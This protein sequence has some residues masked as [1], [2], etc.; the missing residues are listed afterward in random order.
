[1]T[2]TLL[3]LRA[4]HR[5]GVEFIVVGMTAAVLQGTPAVTL[6]LDLVY[7]LDPGNV[8]RLL[9][10]LEELGARF[11]HDDRRIPPDRSHLE[12]RGHKL[13]ETRSGD[14]DILGALDDGAVHGELLP[15]TIVLDV[16]GMPVRV[17]GLRRLIEV[18][19]R[20]GRPKDL[21]VLPLLRSTL[22][23]STGR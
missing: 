23:R 22:E 14:L 12:S 2:D 8:D 7:S 17:L 21:A 20:A 4:L 16:A 5:H 15:D 13:L 9:R 11:R 6:D 1:M 18:K 10:A 19:E 3:L